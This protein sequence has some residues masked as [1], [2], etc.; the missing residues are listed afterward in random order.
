MRGERVETGM[1]E[2]TVVAMGADMEE[3]DL[4]GEIH[5]GCQSGCLMV[6]KIFTI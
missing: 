4:P 5:L 1:V 2:D 3:E 6:F